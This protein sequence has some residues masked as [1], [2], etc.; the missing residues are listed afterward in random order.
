MKRIGEITRETALC[1]V[2]LVV[3]LIGAVWFLA[4]AY[5]EQDR[6]ERKLRQEIHF[7]GR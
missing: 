7:Y 3:V 4:W 2:L 1:I 6:N 5:D